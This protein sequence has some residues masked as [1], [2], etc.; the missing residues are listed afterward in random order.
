MEYV[1][2]MTLKEYIQRFGPIAVPE[3]ISIMKQITA[4]INNA[5]EHNI[6]HRDIKPQNILMDK[7]GQIKVTDLVLQLQLVQ[8]H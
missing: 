3:A 4:A 1:E 2:G 8:Q 7:D 5:H 6:V